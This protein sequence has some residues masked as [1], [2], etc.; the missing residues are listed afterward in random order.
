MENLNV[1][2]EKIEGDTLILREGEALRLEPPNKINIKGDIKTVATFLKARKDKGLGLQNVDI[3]EAL[4]LVNKN[5]RTIKLLVDP[6]N[7]YGAVIEGKLEISDE[8]KQFGINTLQKFSR[9]DLVKLLKMNR[10]FFENKERHSE[11]ILA[12]QKIESSVNYSAKDG[13]DDRGNKERQFV[14]NVTTNAPM[15]FTLNIQIF[16]GFHSQPLTVDICLDIEEG[17]AKFWLESVQLNELM[18]SSVDEIF[19]DELKIADGFVIINQ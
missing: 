19:A 17:T 12:F 7:Y 4:I 11:T 15:S 1:K 18:Q 10:L 8:L 3:D 13:S 2:I 6:E 5:E 16:K 14:K 9:Q